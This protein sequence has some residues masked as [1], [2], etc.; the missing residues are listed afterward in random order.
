ME[1]SSTRAPSSPSGAPQTA[2]LRIVDADAPLMEAGLRSHQ[3][4]QFATRLQEVAG[5]E[6]S[7]TLIFEHPSPRAIAKFIS[8]AD[9]ETAYDVEMVMMLVNALISDDTITSQTPF[10]ADINSTFGVSAGAM[11]PVS[12]FQQH[13]LLLHLL[14]P[15]VAAYTCLLYTSP[16]PRDATL[17]RMPSSA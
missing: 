4:V 17:S 11:L 5:V 2:S 8:E 7:A 16:S 3:A 1:S 10:R 13:F 9:Y 12:S 15:Q 6:Q 14:R